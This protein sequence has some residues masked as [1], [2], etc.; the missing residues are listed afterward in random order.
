[1]IETSYL[2]QKKAKLGIFSPV[3]LHY[4]LTKQDNDEAFQSKPYGIN[5]AKASWDLTFSSRVLLQ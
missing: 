4:Y 1:M 2:V 5:I 3:A